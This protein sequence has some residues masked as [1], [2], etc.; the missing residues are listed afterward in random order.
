MKRNLWGCTEEV[1]TAAYTTLIRPLLEYAAP[2]WDSTNQTNAY[3]LN[4]VQRQAARFCKNEYSREEGTVTKIL[5]DLDWKPLETRRK[6]QRATMLFKIKEG[7][8]DIDPKDHLQ[9]QTR[10]R[11]RGHQHKYRQ[12]RYNTRRYGDTFFPATIPEWNSLPS[13][14]AEA[15]SLDNFKGG[16]RKHF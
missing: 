5:Q 11:T 15:P 10:Q 1:K 16:I 6:I 2:A 8:V 14:I 12:I 3:R 7:L 13:Q 4:R 9:H